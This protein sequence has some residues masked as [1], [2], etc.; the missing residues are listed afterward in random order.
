[1]PTTFIFRCSGCN[2]R[3][4][5]PVLLLGQTRRCPGCKALFIVRPQPP[6]QPQKDAGPML[7]VGQSLREVM[8]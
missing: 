1:M 2:A 5:A 8:S 4:K 6:A 3:I 7:L